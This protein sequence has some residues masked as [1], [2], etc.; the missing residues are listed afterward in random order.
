M[1]TS[2]QIVRLPALAEEPSDLNDWADDPLGR[3]P[4]EALWPE[5]SSIPALERIRRNRAFP[6]YWSA[7]FSRTRSPTRA[8]F[9]SRSSRSLKAGIAHAFQNKINFP[10][11]APRS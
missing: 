7:L 2:G 11:C 1:R 4:G 5:W 10:A 6:R 9:P 8:N 3:E